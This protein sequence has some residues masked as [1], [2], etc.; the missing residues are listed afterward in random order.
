MKLRVARPDLYFD[1]GHRR[2][3]QSR[4]MPYP[5]IKFQSMPSSIKTN[6]IKRSL[7][8]LSTVATF[9]FLVSWASSQESQE[10]WVDDK[11]RALTLEQIHLGSQIGLDILHAQIPILV[12]WGW[13][14]DDDAEQVESSSA[15]S[16]QAPGTAVQA[17][18][19]TMVDAYLAAD[20]PLD[21]IQEVD[22]VAQALERK[23]QRR[24]AA[25]ALALIYRNFQRYVSLTP[26]KLLMRLDRWIGEGFA[27][28]E[29]PTEEDSGG[30]C[31]EVVWAEAELTAMVR[32]G[33]F[34][35]EDANE[36]RAA[37]RVA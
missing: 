36:I 2:M 27:L 29:M 31:A 8:M 30:N 18:A 9:Y 33:I 35:N 4:G 23:C 22:H 1:R 19:R 6:Q 20:A 14:V 17:L 25:D 34:S 5:W 7:D 13:L 32:E 26:R 21:R 16:T 24:D 12:E 3:K 37:G 15:T 11:G 28:V 10:V